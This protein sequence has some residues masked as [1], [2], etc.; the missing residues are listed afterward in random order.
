MLNLRAR[1]LRLSELVSG[2]KKELFYGLEKNAMDRSVEFITE[3]ST[4]ATNYF[5]DHWKLREDAFAK[6]PDTGLL[7]EFGVAK[8]ASANF[9]SAIL[10]KNEDGR[11][12]W[13]F[14]SFEGLS[15]DWGGT[16]MAKGAFD[17]KG[18]SPELNANVECVIG[19]I[20]E[21]Y[22]PFLETH[23]DPI[24]FMHIDTDTYT[25]CYHVLSLSAP[26]FIAGSVVL[27]DE[28]VG[29]PNYHSHELK[30]L[31]EVLPRESY[32][33][34][35]FGIAHQRANLVKSAI[36]ITNPELLV[37]IRSYDQD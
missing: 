5:K 13:G 32:E 2:S 12:Y 27:F 36:Q 11:T 18:N 20:L 10:Q 8:G 35:S 4:A 28:L 29:Y 3:N 33:F 26:R 25:P 30:A 37:S 6:K 19:D 34:L 16:S 7:L 24:A 14:D 15:E 22:A 23:T 21:T 17:R 31:N 9:F 1:I